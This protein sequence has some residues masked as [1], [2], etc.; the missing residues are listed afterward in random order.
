MAFHPEQSTVGVGDRQ[1]V[2]PVVGETAEQVAYHRKGLRQRVRLTVG[3]QL[4]VIQWYGRQ[5]GV[6]IDV[7]GEPRAGHPSILR[8]FAPVRQGTCGPSVPSGALTQVHQHRQHPPAG[9]D[10]RG[11]LCQ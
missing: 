4:V 10:P 7:E 1:Q 11:G 9:A 6:R 3:V 2:P 8:R 5:V